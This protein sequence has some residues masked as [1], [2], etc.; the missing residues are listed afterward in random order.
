MGRAELATGTPSE[1]DRGSALAA[2][3][4]G[5]ILTYGL[6]TL[7]VDGLQVHTE[8][9]NGTPISDDAFIAMDEV[10]YADA[11]GSDNALAVWAAGGRDPG[12][13]LGGRMP[14]SPRRLRAHMDAGQRRVKM[15]LCLGPN[16]PAADPSLSSASERPAILAPATT[17]TERRGEP[18]LRKTPMQLGSEMLLRQASA[19][20]CATRGPTSRR[21][22]NSDISR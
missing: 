6:M 8:Y 11:S 4:D 9:G 5:G 17:A 10:H 3:H 18:S 22:R 15:A 16:L 21:R 14:C 2:W 12:D 7:A 19:V 1:G 20:R 13:H